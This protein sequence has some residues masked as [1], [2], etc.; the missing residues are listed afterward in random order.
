MNFS[1]KKSN[2]RKKSNKYNMIP[3]YSLIFFTIMFIIFI[4]VGI[5][6]DNKNYNIMPSNPVRV[7]EDSNDNDPIDELEEIEPEVIGERPIA[8][9]I[10]NNIGDET[11]AGLQDSYLNYEIIVEGGLTRIMALYNNTTDILI[12]PIRSSR[13]YF[14][15]YAKENDA[16]YAH[17]GNSP[18][19]EEDI[20]NLNIDNINGMVD[21]DPYRRDASLP[22][23]HNVFTKLSYLRKTI[24]EK[25]YNVNSDKWDIFNHSKNDYNLYDKYY[26]ID[27]KYVKRANHI[28]INYSSYQSREYK[29]DSGNK[30]YMRFMNGK[31]HLDKASKQ[32]LHYKNIIIEFVENETIDEEGRQQLYNVGTGEGYYITNGACI[33]IK[34]TKNSRSDK[35]I[36][37][38]K[39]NKEIIVNNG[40][41]FIQI[42]P[43]TGN[44]II[45]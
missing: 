13:H 38:D 32:Q 3:I 21:K 40:N 27:R 1:V 16:I 12:G 42:V 34:W 30:Y 43:V 17:F 44:T 25:G 2:N 23:P 10:D 28:L 8:V 7:V 19:A 37:T 15:D 6:S 29:Y 26:S 35:T 31:E 45:E 22:V 11:H 33:S 14:L 4:L 39:N 9:M 24:G 5:K 41:T 18:Y 36:Y 20:Y